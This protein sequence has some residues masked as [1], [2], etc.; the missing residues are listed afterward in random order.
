MKSFI[1]KH[2][3]G[4]NGV[5]HCFDRVIL[6]GHLPI[7]GTDY[8]LGWLTAKRIGL[9]LRE[10][11]AGWR[12][13]K[14]AAPWFAEQLKRHAQAMAAQAGRPYQHLPSHQKMEA[15]ARAIAERDRIAHGLVC[16]YSTPAR[17]TSP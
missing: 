1:A 15:N 11:P 17:R 12:N 9:N 14:E 5:L 16:V 8:F 6:R 4:I 7:A 10:L 3:A 13:F 2:G